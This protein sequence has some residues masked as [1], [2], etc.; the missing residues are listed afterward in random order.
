[1]VLGTQTGLRNVLRQYIDELRRET[2]D[3]IDAS[4]DGV[5]TKEEF[6]EYLKCQGLRLSAGELETAFVQMDQDDSG[7]VCPYLLPL[8]FS[9]CRSVCIHSHDAQVSADH[10]QVCCTDV[11]FDELKRWLSH[12]IESHTSTDPV[13][14]QLRTKLSETTTHHTVGATCC[15]ATSAVQQRGGKVGDSEA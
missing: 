14:R 9:F 13:A 8:A 2:F 12:N 5:L 6:S 10:W 3:A 15:Y 4:G 11:D 7:C 1:M